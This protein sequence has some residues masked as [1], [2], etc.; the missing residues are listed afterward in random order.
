M[1]GRPQVTITLGRSG[2]VVKRAR[3]TTDVSSS[4]YDAYSEGRGPV[5]ERLGNN[6]VDRQSHEREYNK[7]QRIDNYDRS[8]MGNERQLM[9]IWRID[10]G[11]L[12][13][14]LMSKGL[15]RSKFGS[16]GQNGVDL[17]EKLSRSSHIPLKYESRQSTLESRSP[18][19]SRRIPPARS[20]DDLFRLDSSRSSNRT[21]TFGGLRHRSPDKVLGASKHLSPPRSYNEVRHVPAVRPYDDLR[22]IGQITKSIPDSSRSAAFMNNTPAPFDAVKP[23][24][25]APAGFT[26]NNPYMPEEQ[27][28]VSSLLHSLGLG[29]YAI[30]FQA[31]EVDMSAL[32]QMGDNDLKE[33]GIPMGPR[34]K[35]LLALVQRSKPRHP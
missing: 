15:S 11:D 12:R 24:M 13:H 21:L 3:P 32:K 19:L 34:K 2:Q 28:T 20:A 29:K 14:K 27:P 31:E 4:G 10:R 35:I 5:R 6:L 22:P 30:H 26:Q 18:T 16:E 7:R 25:R 9:P 23:V 8:N 17:R 33:L 1:S